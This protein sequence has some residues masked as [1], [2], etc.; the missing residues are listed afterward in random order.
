MPIKSVIAT[1]RIPIKMWLGE[2]EIE[3]GAL[4]QAKNAANLPFTFKH[5]AMMPDAHQGFG[6]NIG[7]VVATTSNVVIPNCTGVDIGCGMCA[8]RTNLTVDDLD[9][10]TLK[11]ILGEMRERIPVGVGSNRKESLE[12]LMPDFEV[13]ENGNPRNMPENSV[14]KREWQKATH[15]LG[16]LGSNNHFLELQKDENNR[17]WIMLHSGSRNL[18]YQVANYYNDLAVELNEKWYSS[19]PKEWKLA[20]LPMDEGGTDYLAEM[21]YCLEFALAN[22]AKMLDDIM[23]A[24][25][26]NISSVEFIEDSYVNIH[27]NYAQLEHHFNKNVMVHRKG[28]TSARNGEMG[29]IPGSQG[30]S[31]Y[32]VRGLGNPDSFTSC[33]HGAGRIMSRTKAKEELD[34]KEEKGKLDEKGILHAIRHKN[35]LDEAS[36]AYKDIDE[37]MKNQNDL[38]EIV[39]KLQPLAVVKG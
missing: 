6:I 28:A 2:N 4:A 37:V 5:I 35:D 19:V 21:N 23:L 38:V 16:S 12:D 34:L 36:G 25:E 32:I 31:S 9:T 17:I 29:I 1:E 13:D 22:R 10:D 15:A 33:S 26:N 24:F 30:T 18:G 39:E 7:G 14:V 8:I 27:H 3:E 11:S 20:F